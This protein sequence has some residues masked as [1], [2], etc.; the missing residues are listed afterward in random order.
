MRLNVLILIRQ[1]VVNLLQ[2]ADCLTS[3]CTYYGYAWRPTPLGTSGRLA[4][5]AHPVRS[6]CASVWLAA[7]LSVQDQTS[8]RKW[9]A[10]W[11]C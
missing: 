4:G 6:A 11:G 2:P 9:D 1:T 7:W 8:E 10:T 3:S 5:E